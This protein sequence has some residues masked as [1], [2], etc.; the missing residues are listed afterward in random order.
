[1]ASTMKARTLSMPTR[2]IASLS[3]AFVLGTRVSD[4]LVGFWSMD[5]AGLCDAGT[6]MKTDSGVMRSLLFCN[7]RKGV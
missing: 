2:R 5:A 6:C 3:R 1:M 7:P 4:D